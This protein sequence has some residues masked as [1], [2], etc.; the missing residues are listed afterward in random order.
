MLYGFRFFNGKKITK[1]NKCDG[2]I[3]RSR[4]WYHS[5]IRGTNSEVSNVDREIS[6]KN[7]KVK[8]SHAV[9]VSI[10]NPVT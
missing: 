4:T 10:I 9:L 6:I 2:K 7:R 8:N 3:L 5:D 1:W